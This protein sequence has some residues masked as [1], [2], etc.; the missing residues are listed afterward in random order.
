MRMNMAISQISIHR[1]YT[2]PLHPSY[3]HFG[4]YLDHQ[5][6]QCSNMGVGEQLP[7]IICG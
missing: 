7:E 4:M 2:I 5:Q 6:Q 1:K 3:M